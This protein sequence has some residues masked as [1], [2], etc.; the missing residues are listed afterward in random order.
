MVD[1]QANDTSGPSSELLELMSLRDPLCPTKPLPRL[2]RRVIPDP[3]ASYEDLRRFR[4]E[5]VPSM[6]RAQRD[7]ESWRLRTSCALVEDIARVP[8]WVF[9]RLEVLAA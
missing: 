4:H 6:T 5:D 7:W 9:T 8:H 3:L 1:P 2:L